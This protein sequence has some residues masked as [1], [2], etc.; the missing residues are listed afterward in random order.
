MTEM[1]PNYSQMVSNDF[2]IVPK[3]SQIVLGDNSDLDYTGH[4]KRPF[5]TFMKIIILMEWP[6]PTPFLEN[7]MNFF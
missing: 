1:V 4:F 7:S 5:F 6:N 2:Q 3:D